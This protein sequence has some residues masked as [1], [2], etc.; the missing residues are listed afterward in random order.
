MT[1]DNDN[2]F[3]KILREEIPCK[4]IYEDNFVL[5]LLH[6]SSCT[7]KPT[8]TTVSATI[9][10]KNHHHL[11]KMLCFL[12]DAIAIWLFSLLQ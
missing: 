10:V 11:R 7:P 1:Y 12:S 6:K 5:S 2:I 3:A 8:K 9:N 4:K